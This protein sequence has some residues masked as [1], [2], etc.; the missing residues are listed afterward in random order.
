M[1]CWRCR[2]AE[3]QLELLSHSACSEVLK[4]LA[5][6]G[7]T[8]CRQV[9]EE[10]IGNQLPLPTFDLNA[11]SPGE[12]HQLLPKRTLPPSYLLQLNGQVHQGGI[13]NTNSSMQ[14]TRNSKETKHDS[15]NTQGPLPGIRPRAI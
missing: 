4:G 14:I 10:G 9:L 3:Q 13:L 2:L 15:V 11:R 12:H 6:V 5:G 8:A 1:C 7:E